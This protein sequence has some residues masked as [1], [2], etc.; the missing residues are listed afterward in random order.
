MATNVIRMQNKVKIII[1]YPIKYPYCGFEHIDLDKVVIN[2]FL[3]NGDRIY[4]EDI[5]SVTFKAR[6]DSDGEDTED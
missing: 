6:S 1:D 5:K 2:V 4:Q 3:K